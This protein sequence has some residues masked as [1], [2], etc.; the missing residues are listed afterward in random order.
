MSKWRPLMSGVPQGLV[1]GPTLFNIFVGDMDSEIECTLSK[2]TNSPKL[3]AAVN[4]LE[5][6]DAIQK[7]F[8]RLERWACVN[9]MMFNKAKC[10][11]LHVG[12]GNPKHSYRLGGE[13]IESSPEEKDLGMLVD[14]K[15]NMTWQC[16][17]AAQKANRV[18]GCIKRSVTSRSR[19]VI[20]PLHSAL[21]RPHLEHCIQ[22]WG[23]QHKKD[24]WSK[25]RVGPRR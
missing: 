6:R 13:W 18:L 21:V 14:E 2:F 16:A 12:R 8:D 5:G 15:L 25:S 19:E 24:C 3:C 23:P 10:K 17:L 7:D 1:L 4:T 20:L 11:V 9:L 22:L